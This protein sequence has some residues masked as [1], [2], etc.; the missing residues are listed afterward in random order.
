MVY[1]QGSDLG[2]V[3]MGAGKRGS[4]AKR[5]LAAFATGGLSEFA[6]AK[7]SKSKRQRK[8]ARVFGGLLTGGLSELKYRKK[9]RKAVAA[10]ATGGLSLMRKNKKLQ[11]AALAFATGGA[12]LLANKKVALAV[13]G[14]ASGGVGLIPHLIKR[15]QARK[16]AGAKGSP[17]VPASVIAAND[18]NTPVAATL[19]AQS[20]VYATQ[21]EEQSEAEEKRTEQEQQAAEG[22][23]PKKGAGWLALIPLAAIPFLFG[24]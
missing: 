7:R 22:N 23:T 17:D 11:R 24:E 3:Y 4:K 12:S 15:A 8:A 10:F 21:Q 18:V 2:I 19:E 6:Y 20:P 13:G 16:A 5:T 14:V 9:A 1:L